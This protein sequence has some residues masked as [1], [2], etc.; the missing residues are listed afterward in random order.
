MIKAAVGSVKDE[1]ETIRHRVDLV[2]LQTEYLRIMRNPQETASDGTK[3]WF[4]EFV[5]KHGIR[6]N[7]VTKTEK[8]VESLQ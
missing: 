5:L 2:R 6:I 1:D 4:C 7:E 8:F 3:E